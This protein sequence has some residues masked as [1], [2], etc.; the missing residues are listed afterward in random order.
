MSCICK[1]SRAYIYHN[2]M[3]FIKLC[4]HSALI[5]RHCLCFYAIVPAAFTYECP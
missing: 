5:Q 1:I 4:F 2:R 3:S